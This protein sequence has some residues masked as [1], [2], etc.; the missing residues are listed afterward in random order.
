[1]VAS[2]LVEGLA[3]IGKSGD[4]LNWL[5]GCSVLL[6]KIWL[7]P[8]N[9]IAGGLHQARSIFRIFENHMIAAGNHKPVVHDSRQFEADGASTLLTAGKALAGQ[10]RRLMHQPMVL[11]VDAIDTGAWNLVSGDKSC[12]HADCSRS[13]QAHPVRLWMQQRGRKVA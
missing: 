13:G 5:T 1:M 11:V 10:Q 7:P 8:L 2:S 6:K 4:G 3:A 12:V 9:L